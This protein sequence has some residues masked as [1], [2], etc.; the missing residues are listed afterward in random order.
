[1]RRL[2]NL[3]CVIELALFLIVPLSAWVASVLGANIVNLISEEA[4]RWFFNNG[5]S[6]LVSPHLALLILA[7][8]AIAAVKESQLSIHISSLLLHHKRHSEHR[9]AFLGALIFFMLVLLLLVLPVIFNYSALMSVSGTFFPS[10]P[11]LSGFPLAF[12]ID[13][14][15]SSL[16]YATF[17]SQINGV[18]SIVNLFT[19]G[20]Q[21]YGIWFVDVM[22]GGVLY[23][24]IKYCI[25]Y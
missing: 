16:I 21:R 14:I 8:T 17:S 6:F 5:S 18:E 1:M 19:Q 22:M 12:C 4:I 20:F 9:K 23:H 15:L 7:L 3:L 24:I 11:W 25:S 13:V 10:S 2:A